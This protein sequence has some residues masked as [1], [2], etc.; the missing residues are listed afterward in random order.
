MEDDEQ[1][2]GNDREIDVN[3]NV[4]DI[5][6]IIQNIVGVDGEMVGMMMLSVDADGSVG[7]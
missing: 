7:E 1:I 2:I 4:D 3:I 6:F 5:Y